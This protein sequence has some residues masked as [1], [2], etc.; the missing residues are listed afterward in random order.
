MPRHHAYSYYK[1][2]TGEK[3]RGR[4][5]RENFASTTNLA[6]KCNWEGKRNIRELGTTKMGSGVSKP[7]KRMRPEFII[8]ED[9]KRSHNT[10]KKLAITVLFINIKLVVPNIT[11][12]LN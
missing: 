5:G 10:L 6:G 9:A 8:T 11:R 1:G 2:E 7:L 4:F 3:G 12:F